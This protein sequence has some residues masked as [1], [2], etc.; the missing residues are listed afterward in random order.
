MPQH[1]V[2]ASC[3][4][5]LH[6]QTACRLPVSP[7]RNLLGLRG[8]GVVPSTVWNRF[9]RELDTEPCLTDTPTPRQQAVID[10][11]VGRCDAGKD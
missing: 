4:T 7:T 5:S 8:S 6:S 3:L 9:E 11:I 2:M 1:L 10:R